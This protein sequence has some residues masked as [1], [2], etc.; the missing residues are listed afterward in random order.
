MQSFFWAHK[1]PVFFFNFFKAFKMVT[2]FIRWQSIDEF[3]PKK[4]EKKN[5]LF[6]VSLNVLEF[7]KR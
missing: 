6:K 1:N 4:I 2:T 3:I 5:L 7:V